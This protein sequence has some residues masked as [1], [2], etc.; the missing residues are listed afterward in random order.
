MHLIAKGKYR[1]NMPVNLQRCHLL[2][3]WHLDKAHWFTLCGV[4]VGEVF[5]KSP[6]LVRFNLHRFGGTKQV[7]IEQS[8][9]TTQVDLIDCLLKFTIEE[10]EDNFHYLHVSL[11]SQ[12]R[13]LRALWPII[14]LMF[15]LTVV[16]DLAYYAGK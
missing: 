15:F 16:E 1:F 5:V 8:D 14:Q 4:S 6:T 10:T 12:Y 13:I 7:C 11:F 3:I 2:D 9:N